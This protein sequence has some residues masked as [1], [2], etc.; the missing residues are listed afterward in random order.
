MRFTASGLPP[1]LQLDEASGRIIGMLSAAGRH[2]VTLRAQNGLGSIERPLTIVAGEEI[3]LT[4]PMGWSSWNCWGGRVTQERVSAAARALVAHQL[5]EHGWTYVNIDDGWQGVRGGEHN[6]IQPNSK[7]PN[8]AALA[9]EV[10]S[11]GLKFGIYSTPWRTSF[12]GHIGSSADHPDGTTDWIREKIHTGVFKYRFPKEESRLAQHAWLR[13]LSDRLKER[14]RAKITRQLRTF[15]KFSFAAED[16]RQWGAWDVDYLKYDWVPIDLPHTEEM[17]RHLRATGRDIVYSVANNAPFAIAS[18]LTRPTN[19]WR[20]ASDLKDTWRHLEDIG[21]SRDRWAPFQK[22]G[23]YNDPDMLQIGHV[24]MGEPRPTRLTANEQYT[25]ISLWCLL[26]A[27]LLL[28]CDLDKLDAFTLGLITN[29]EV[30]AINQDPLCK[31]A[32]QVAK[33]GKRAVYVKPLEDGS[34]AVGLFNRGERAANVSVKWS[35]LGLRGT[36]SVR[37]LWRQKDLGSFADGV[38]REVAGHG[39]YLLR[40]GAAR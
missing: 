2:S 40:V 16:A 38:E 32:T 6:A 24:G 8:M 3:A 14:K 12:F 9:G 22:P 15:G 13:P 20:T 21:F 5:R 17:G 4:P 34:W 11:L 25:H 19:A 7:F 36:Q 28:G 39:V 37:D 33:S 23:H 10:H 29:D 1:G 18:E 30:L 31:Q 26:G 35:D 27:P